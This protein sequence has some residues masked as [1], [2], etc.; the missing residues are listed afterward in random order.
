ML[1][2][3]VRAC[4]FVA[5]ISVA[6][7]ADAQIVRVGPFGGVRVRAPFVSVDVLPYGGGTRVRA[8]FTAVD[9]GPYGYPPGFPRAYRTLPGYR[10]PPVY[11]AP[12]YPVPSYPRSGGYVY[13]QPE[14]RQQSARPATTSSARTALAV[15]AQQLKRNLSARRND[16]QVWLDYLQPD[17]IIDAMKR[18]ESA[19]SLRNLLGNYDGV[20][21]NGGLSSVSNTPG[22]RETHA[23]LRALIENRTTA[24][25]EKPA[26][27]KQSVLPPEPAPIP[28][29]QQ[30]TDLPEP[31]PADKRGSEEIPLPNVPTPL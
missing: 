1:R 26:P 24:D 10:T 2:W 8:P 7:W 12:V 25:A 23:W 16:S 15:A 27:S 13:P 28:P 30:D 31:P 3:S 29:P 9:A 22:F 5:L 18:G 14:D 11:P 17:R 6:S 19:D 20:V 4:C 21:A